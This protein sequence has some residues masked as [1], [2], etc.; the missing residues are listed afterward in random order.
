MCSVLWRHL[1]PCF[2]DILFRVLEAYDF[3]IQCI[4]LNWMSIPVNLH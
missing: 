2:G 3:N 4:D 1:I